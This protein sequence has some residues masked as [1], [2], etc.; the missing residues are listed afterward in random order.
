SSLAVSKD[1]IYNLGGRD[2]DG[3]IL[4]TLTSFNFSFK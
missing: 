2:L 4:N 3:K 1:K